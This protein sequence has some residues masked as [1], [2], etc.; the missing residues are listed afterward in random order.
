MIGYSPKF[1]LQ[2]NNEVGAYAL[3]QT[4]K[5][6]TIQN[7]KNLLLTSPGE[8]IMDKN[9]GVGVRNY[10]FEL[11]TSSTHAQ[12]ARNIQEQTRRYM[13]FITLNNIQFN[14]GVLNPEENLLLVISVNFS[15]PQA[16][17]DQTLI[18]GSPQSSI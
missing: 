5:E 13:S 4:T 11:N 16:L 17:G 9:F 10:L 1:P 3:T 14:E 7:Y 8:R 2:I 18:I 12:I 15:L 6:V